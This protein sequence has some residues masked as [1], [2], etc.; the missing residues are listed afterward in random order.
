VPFSMAPIISVDKGATTCLYLTG[1]PFLETSAFG[2]VF[3]P[4]PVPE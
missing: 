3:P 2:L 1:W 4:Q